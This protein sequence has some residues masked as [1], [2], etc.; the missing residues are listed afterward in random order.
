MT[1][2]KYMDV[3]RSYIGVKEIPGA[4]HNPTIMRWLT[5]LRSWVKDDETPWCGTFVAEC[6]R[7]SGYTYPTLYMRAMSWAS[8]G[9]EVKLP[10]RGCVVVFQRQGGGHV[11]F[12]EG[13]DAKGNLMVLGGNQSNMVR[14][15]PFSV[16]RVVAYRVPKGF[17]PKMEDFKLPLMASDGK[18][19]TNEA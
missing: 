8:W 15:S 4:K 13:Q 11:G 6:M 18:L 7:A 2:F 10:I 12:V 1:A 3:A 9:D 19:S 5:A 16:D 17:V 14:V